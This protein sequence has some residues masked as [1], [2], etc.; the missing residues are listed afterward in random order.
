MRIRVGVDVV[1]RVGINVGVGTLGRGCRATGLLGTLA[2]GGGA[3]GA[4]AIERRGGG[5]VDLLGLVGGR[6]VGRRGGVRIGVAVGVGVEVVIGVGD[7]GRAAALLGATAGGSGRVRRGRVGVGRGLAVLL[8]SGGV[9]SGGLGGQARLALGE[10][11]GRLA[12]GLVGQVGVVVDGPPSWRGR[13]W[14]RR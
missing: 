3:L 13:R 11:L 6:N 12:I 10:G 5:L 8:G 4:Q 14:R 2:H 7:V 9:G 1:V